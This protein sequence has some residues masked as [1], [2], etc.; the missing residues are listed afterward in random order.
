MNLTTS[1]LQEP[2]L[3]SILPYHTKKK[4]ELQKTANFYRPEQFIWNNP[5]RTSRKMYNYY[6]KQNDTFNMTLKPKI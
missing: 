2:Y 1:A 5:Y 6:H 3:S 4:D